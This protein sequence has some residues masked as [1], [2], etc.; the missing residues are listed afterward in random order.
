[1]GKRALLLTAVLACPLLGQ[2]LPR[3]GEERVG[4]SAASALKALGSARSAGLVSA[5]TALPEP[6]SVWLNPAVAAEQQGRYALVLAS[7]RLIAE[8][9]HHALCVGYRF[10]E[11]G[12]VA[13]SFSVVS[14][15]PIEETTEFRPYG[16]GRQFRFGQWTAALS[17]AHRFTEQF[18]AGVTLRYVQENWAEVTLRGITWDAGTFYW[19]GIGSLRLAV[20]VSHFGL[21]L[22]AVGPLPEQ[23]AP[24]RDFREFAPPTVF[25]IGLAGELLHDA[26]Q[27]WTWVAS[28]EH[29]SDQSESYA[30]GSE[31]AVRFSSAFPAE[32]LVRAGLRAQAAQWWAVGVGVRLPLA[33]FTLQLDYAL[34]A[35]PPF[36]LAHRFGCTVEPFRGP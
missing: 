2:I 10:W 1:M 22:R 16:T 17:Y 20:A 12:T 30:V 31:Y 4:S 14:L 34:T 21:P 13:L 32:L 36:G 29:P 35:Q 3:F 6:G 8:V 19:T 28:V 18:A 11:P 27:R 33:P 24:A 5:T 23:G 26:L 9:W 25:R 15:P 7:Q